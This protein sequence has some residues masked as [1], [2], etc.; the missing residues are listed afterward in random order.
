MRLRSWMMLACL[1]VVGAAELSA[2]GRGRGRGRRQS[3][4]EFPNA[5][6]DGR[7]VF[8]RIS[9]TDFEGYGP[10]LGDGCVPWSHDYPRAERNFL[11]ILQEL[12]S[13][14]VR[15]GASTMLSLDNPELFRFPVAYMAEP[16][17]WRPSET[18][19]LNMRKYLQKGGF[20][21][22]DD[23]A[24]ERD[25]Q[26]FQA[27]IQR[28]L[29]GGR[30]V[31]LDASHPIFDAFYRIPSLDFN[32]PIYGMQARFFGVFENNDP[33]QRLLMIANFNN[34]LSEYWQFSDE[35]YFPIDLSNE[36]YKLGINYIVYA[37][38][39]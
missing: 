13:V 4:E 11:K 24:R 22:F 17:H 23:F 34:D 21:I 15:G 25:W 39:R 12:T 10:C 26:N 6:Y 31:Q 8:A 7:F 16:G 9:Y 36:A 30:L 2:Q 37:L 29:P 14:S 3:T 18:E 33:T 28:V 32:H 19:V 5:E 20:F 27:Q 38:S 1:L 35:G